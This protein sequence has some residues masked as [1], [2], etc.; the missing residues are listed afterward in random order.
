MFLLNKLMKLLKVQT[1]TK[2]I[3]SNDS[4]ETYASRMSMDLA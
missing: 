4:I 2:K 3:Q 1:M